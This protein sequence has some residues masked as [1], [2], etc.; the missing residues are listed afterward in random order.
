MDPDDGCPTEP[1]DIDDFEDTD[2]C[3]DPDND[4]DGILDVDDACPLRAEIVNGINDED[5]CPD[6]GIIT[7]VE[8][9]VVLGE[10]VLL[11]KTV[12]G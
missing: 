10:T 8:D 7:M 3:P 11:T 6:E 4:R 5:G 2:G 12:H 9:R 1:E